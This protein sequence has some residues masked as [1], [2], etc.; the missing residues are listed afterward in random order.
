VSF[1]ENVIN[2]AGVSRNVFSMMMENALKLAFIL[3]EYQ[4]Y[5]FIIIVIRTFIHNRGFVFFF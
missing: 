3:T 5:S 1:L 4:A 2:A